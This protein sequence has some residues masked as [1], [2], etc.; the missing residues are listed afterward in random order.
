LPRSLSRTSV[1]SPKQG[2]SHQVGPPY[3]QDVLTPLPLA[4]ALLV[5]ASTLLAAAMELGNPVFVFYSYWAV[6]LAGQ[7]VGA[8]KK[9]G[10]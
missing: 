6:I 10:R 1:G 3:L 9:N 2:S 7:L 5:L 4:N 8:A